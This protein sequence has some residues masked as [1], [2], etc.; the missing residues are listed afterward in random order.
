MTA[1]RTISQKRTRGLWVLAILLLAAV[2][3][4]LVCPFIGM[5]SIPFAAVTGNT[6]ELKTLHA[7]F[8][9]I[10]IPRVLIGFFAGAG[11][12]V[13]GMAFQALFHNPLATPFTL[14][15]A[16]GASMGAALYVRLGLSFA[17][18]S[19]SGISVFAFVGALGA[20]CLV[21]GLT[22][23]RRGF[24]TATMLLAGIAVNLFFSSLILFVQYMSGFGHSVR[25][26][27]WL[28]GGLDVFEYTD[29]LNL[30]PLV[31]VGI[32]T[33]YVLTHELNLLTIGE[34]IAISRGVNVQ[35]VKRIL[36]VATSVCVGGVVAV[37]GPIGFIG[38]MAPH[39]CR[40]LVGGNHR[41]LLPATCL[42]GGAFLTL[43]DT[44]SRTLIA[45]AE[46]PVGVITSI[47]G[48]PFFIWLLVRSPSGG[49]N[50]R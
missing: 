37:C 20:I 17:V 22:R 10:R 13:C 36:F 38:M 15:V 3:C 47:L 5:E 43:C 14:G 48:G 35:I 44:A 32:L 45:P 50:L 1:N 40:L 12:A 28:M 4:L 6:D 42:F 7:I 46:I 23:L 19:I 21:Y 24:S 34:E 30:A 8:W 25:I 2:G 16:S 41:L 33:L 18:L 49:L 29:F 31:I 27:R 9:R 26:L 11:L 39:I